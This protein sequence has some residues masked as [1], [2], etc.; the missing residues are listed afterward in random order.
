M[1]ISIIP[2]W[3]ELDRYTV[4]SNCEVFVKLRSVS[5]K[6]RYCGRGCLK[7]IGG[8]DE[9]EDCDNRSLLP[10][11]S[12]KESERKTRKGAQEQEVLMGQSDYTRNG[13]MSA[14]T[15]IRVPQVER[16]GREGMISKYI[17]MIYFVLFCA[18]YIHT[19]KLVES[20]D[21]H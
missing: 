13:F 10:V 19:I 16:L 3:F 21:V 18:P 9:N 12:C 17:L 15:A 2:F 20:V 8:L 5:R 14:P 1:K 4:R 11:R 6:V 7:R